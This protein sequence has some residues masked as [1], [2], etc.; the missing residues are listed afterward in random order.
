[1][2]ETF[3]MQKLH[4]G[5]KINDLKKHNKALAVGR[6]KRPRAAEAHRWAG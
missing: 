2:R 3:T 6:A 5:V 1:V 4:L